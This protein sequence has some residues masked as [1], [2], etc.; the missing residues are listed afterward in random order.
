MKNS[1]ETR[2]CIGCRI[3]TK[4]QN[5]LRI[6]KLKD[7]IIVDFDQ[8]LKARGTYICKNEECFNKM[9][10]N[11]SLNKALKTKISDEKYENIRG[12]IFDR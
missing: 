6:V 1:K 9:Q 5:L 3:K 4:K 2:T 8:K 11:K 12:V 10:K 7:E